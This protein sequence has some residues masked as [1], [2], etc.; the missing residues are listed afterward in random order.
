MVLY[1]AAAAARSR[2]TRRA[3]SSRVFSES[4]LNPGLRMR[5]EDVMGR[6]FPVQWTQ[7]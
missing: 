3:A 1:L 7:G 4:V 2:V 5:V 6:L